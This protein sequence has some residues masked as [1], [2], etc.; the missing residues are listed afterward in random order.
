[1]NQGSL[2]TIAQEPAES[3][4]PFATRSGKKKRKGNR[5]WRPG[6]NTNMIPV[7]TPGQQPF[8]EQAHKLAQALHRQF[9]GASRRK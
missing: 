7:A 2:P 6:S 5:F 8:Q 1:M 4:E 9:G 3:P